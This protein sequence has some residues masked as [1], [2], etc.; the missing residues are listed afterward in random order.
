[1]MINKKCISQKEIGHNLK[2]AQT[3]YNRTVYVS[4]PVGGSGSGRNDKRNN[5]AHKGGRGE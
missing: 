5:Q 1:M 2:N 4:P 3:A